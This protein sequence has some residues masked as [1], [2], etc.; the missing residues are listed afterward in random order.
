MSNEKQLRKIREK[1]EMLAER[2]RLCRIEAISLSVD[3]KKKF[4]ERVRHANYVAGV[5]ESYKA[6]CEEFNIDYQSIKSDTNIQ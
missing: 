4:E 6:M 2:N 3:K 1:L 5:N